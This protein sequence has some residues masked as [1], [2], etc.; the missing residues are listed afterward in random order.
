MCKGAVKHK[1][2]GKNEKESLKNSRNKFDDKFG[3]V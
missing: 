1:R 3:R 2:C